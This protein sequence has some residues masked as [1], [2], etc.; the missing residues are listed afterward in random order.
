MS[1]RGSLR[2]DGIEVSVICPGF[3]RSP[4]TDVNPFPMPLLM[5]TD[6]AAA[7]IKRRPLWYYWPCSFSNLLVLRKASATSPAWNHHAS[8]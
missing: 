1:L 8:F 6:R 2:G 4:M 3:V 5:E 7:L